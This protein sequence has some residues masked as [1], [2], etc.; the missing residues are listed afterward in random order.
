[1]PH[2]FAAK[3]GV[4]LPPPPTHPAPPPP[5]VQFG[6]FFLILLLLLL[7]CS[8]VSLIQALNFTQ[9][10]LNTITSIIVC[11]W[12][13]ANIYYYSQTAKKGRSNI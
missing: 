6:D 13:P 7:E 1:M 3:G 2:K 10:P 4:I 9:Q 5:K 8:S 12:V 11:M